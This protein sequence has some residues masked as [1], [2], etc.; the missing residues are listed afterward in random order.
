MQDSIH[1]SESSETQDIE[2]SQGVAE[3]TTETEVESAVTPT[4]AR[5]KRLKKADEDTL[6]KKAISCMEKA[7]SIQ[8]S[9]EKG[10]QDAD[11]IFAKFLESELRSIHDTRWKEWC[12]WQIQSILHQ[13]HMGEL[14][15]I[16]NLIPTPTTHTPTPNPNTSF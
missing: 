2:N 1:E 12:K 7:I 16:Q 4:P 9:K 10:T 15:G 14:S 3:N 13:V 11:E 6:L 8:P 5:C